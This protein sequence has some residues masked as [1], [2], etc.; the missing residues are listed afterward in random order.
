MRLVSI[1][2]DQ[3]SCRDRTESFISAKFHIGP[4]AL[5]L[6]HTILSFISH[7]GRALTS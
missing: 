1:T 5:T 4:V 3:I 7:S 2:V 6:L